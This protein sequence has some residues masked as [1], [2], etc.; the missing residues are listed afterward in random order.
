MEASSSVWAVMSSREAN[1]VSKR[2]GV[3]KLVD[4]SSQ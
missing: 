4:K 3:M 2:R 1:A